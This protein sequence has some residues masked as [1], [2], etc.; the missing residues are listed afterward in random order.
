MQTIK[1][2]LQEMVDNE[3]A[4]VSV[5][6]SPSYIINDDNN[7][8]AVIDIKLNDSVIGSA[9]LSVQETMLL[10]QRLLDQVRNNAI[11]LND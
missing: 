8:R 3:E 10:V 4:R 7:F 2:Q 1:K 11:W 6:T 5:S 9:E